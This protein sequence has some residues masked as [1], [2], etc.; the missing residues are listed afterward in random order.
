MYK[1]EMG[2]LAILILQ[3]V[4]IAFSLP[5]FLALITLKDSNILD[6]IEGLL[7]ITIR[8]VSIV[9]NVWVYDRCRWKCAELKSKN[10]E[11]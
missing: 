7:S 5:P 8:F 2:I 11:V 1:T 9:I 6:L 10:I 3:T 4:S